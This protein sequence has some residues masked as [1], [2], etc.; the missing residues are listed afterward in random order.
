MA[1]PKEKNKYFSEKVDE[2]QCKD[3]GMALVLICLL[4]GFYWGKNIFIFLA[5]PILVITMTVPTLYRPFAK[6][7][8]G[9]SHLLG[10]FVSKI[11]LTVIFYLM[12][13]PIGFLRRLMGKDA[14]QIKEWKKDTASAFAVREHVFNADEIE[15]PY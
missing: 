13:T 8:L 1:N 11:I 10:T 6:I 14:L 4:I 5:I 7:W 15:K 12:V 2:H 3:S 9:L